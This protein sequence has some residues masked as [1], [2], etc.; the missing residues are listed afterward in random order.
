MIFMDF[1]K[2]KDYYFMKCFPVQKYR[3]EFNNGKKMYIN[4]VQH[5]HDSI[6]GFQQDFEGGVFRQEPNTSAYLLMTKSDLTADEAIDKAI[7]NRLKDDELIMETSDF[8]IYIN[9]Y[10][11]CLT[12]IPKQYINFA[13]NSIVFNSKFNIASEFWHLLNQYSNNK[14]SYFSVYNAETFMNIFYTEMSRKG[15]LVESGI[16]RYEKLDTEK[17]I[18]YSQSD[19]RKLVFTKDE[20]YSYQNEF[21]FFIRQKNNDNTLDHLEVV[22]VDLRPS[23]I[24]SYAYLSPEYAEELKLTNKDNEE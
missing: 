14:Y 15:F 6:N 22:G 7:N 12:I 18:K 9:G 1:S 4:S 3:D 17:R 23:L 24:K 10:I 19:M 2:F 11:L 5:F 8:K 16:V 20:K 13:E 21:R